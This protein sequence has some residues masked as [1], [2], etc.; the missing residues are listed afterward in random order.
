MPHVFLSYVRENEQQADR[1]ATDLQ[2]AGA[3]VWL[4][5]YN[6]TAGQR[7]QDAI[8]HAIQSDICA[9][10]HV[11]LNDDAQLNNWTFERFILSF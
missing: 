11:G 6:I 2:A 10:I 9:V 8:R 7:W 1:I 5:R 4:D 3:S